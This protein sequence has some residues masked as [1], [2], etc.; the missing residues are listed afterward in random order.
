[1]GQPQGGGVEEGRPS[2]ER[3]ESQLDAASNF[4]FLNSNRPPPSPAQEVS[5]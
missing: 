2:R 3:Q 1:M 5:G 4:R